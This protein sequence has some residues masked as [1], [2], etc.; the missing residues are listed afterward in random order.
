[1]LIFVE[2]VD[3]GYF[4]PW[5]FRSMLC[6][7]YFGSW[8]FGSWYFGSWY[9]GSWYFGS[10]YF[11]TWYFGILVLDAISNKLNFSAFINKLY[12]FVSITVSSVIFF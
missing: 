4:G 6:S 7:G 1:M 8:Y 12:N 2:Y 5:Y 3:S 10:W 11:G 9:F